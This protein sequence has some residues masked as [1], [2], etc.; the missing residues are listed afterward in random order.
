VD[1]AGALVTQHDSQPRGGQ[2]PTSIWSP[3]EV[4]EDTLEVPVSPG[5]YQVFVGLYQWDTGARLP[6]LLAGQAQADDQLPLGEIR[7]P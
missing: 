4:V 6:V 2:Y 5:T 3:G 7:V 1:S